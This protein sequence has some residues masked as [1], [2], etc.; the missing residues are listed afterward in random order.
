MPTCRKC[1]REYAAGHRF[2][3]VDGALLSA[4][5]DEP[6]LGSWLGDDFRLVEVAGRG[7]S[8]TV[9]RAF[10]ASMERFVA[11]KVLHPDLV[12]SSPESVRR[13]GREARAVARLSHPNIVSVIGAGTTAD[14]APYLVME[15]VEGASLEEALEVGALPIDRSLHIARQV[16][17][18]LAESHAAGVVHR[19]LK[20]ANLLLEQRRL[21]GDFVKILDFGLAKLMPEALGD[22]HESQLTRAGTVCGT[23]HYIAPEQAVAEPLDHRADLYSLGVILY[24][25]VTGR[26]PFDGTGMAVLLAHASQK[27]AAPHEL[28]PR[29]DRRLSALI[30]RCLEKRPERRFQSAEDL[31][32]ALD[33]LAV[34]GKREGEAAH[35]V[36]A[37][38]AAVRSERARVRVGVSVAVVALLAVALAFVGSRFE[39]ASRSKTRDVAGVHAPA[40]GA[41]VTSPVTATPALLASES[42]G[43]PGS[44]RQR[45]VVVAEGGYSLRVSMPERTLVG[46]DYEIL[47]EVWDPAGEPLVTSE[48]IVT[49][50]DPRGNSRGVAAK[51]TDRPG[52]YRFRRAFEVGGPHTIRVFPPSGGAT[53]RLFFDVLAPG[54]A[55]LTQS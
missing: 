44:P 51:P 52:R 34:A 33:A 22:G 23:P 55:S 19:D 47:V 6:R 20:P 49:I 17:A 48:L 8:G 42:A 41:A 2:C 16:V 5:A 7:T 18:A 3:P 53:I 29:I 28:D 15:Y 9:Y 4:A 43:P 46:I 38:L 45:V 10:Q 40:G 39:R 21:N 12:D 14:G 26:L 31:A 1:R 24:R 30:M 13:M 27:P 50:D 35:S 32:E 54:S 11:V 25:M 37:Q 36:T